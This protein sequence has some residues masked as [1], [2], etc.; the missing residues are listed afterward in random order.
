MNSQHQ[1]YQ[2]QHDGGTT[3]SAQQPGMTWNGSSW[4]PSATDVPP[5]PVKTYTRYYHEWTA[6]LQEQQ[7][8]HQDGSLVLAVREQAQQQAAWYKYHAD[9]SSRAAHH[10]H[11]NPA[12]STAPFDLPP[13][14]TA[15]ETATAGAPG[16]VLQQIH[17][18]RAAVAH[19]PKA[20]KSS[21]Q[22]SFQRYVDGCLEQCITPAEKAAVMKLVHQEMAKTM[23]EG[24]LHSTNWDQVPLVPVPGRVMP[25]TGGGGD[26]HYVPPAPDSLQRYVDGCLQQCS[27]P[28]EKTA[29]MKQVHQEMAKRMK[30]E[31]T[32]N[33]TNWDQVPLV[34]VPGRVMPATGGGGGDNHYVPPLATP[35]MATAATNSSDIGSGSTPSSDGDDNHYGP[36]SLTTAAPASPGC[37]A[38]QP[39]PPQSQKRAVTMATLDSELDDS[40]D[41]D[42]GD[43]YLDDSTDDDS[44]DDYLE[45]LFERTIDNRANYH[46]D[47]DED[48]YGDGGMADIV[49]RARMAGLAVPAYC[50]EYME[51]M[52]DD[53]MQ[54]RVTFIRP[55]GTHEVKSVGWCIDNGFDEVEDG[56]WSGP[57]YKGVR[58]EH[59]SRQSATKKPASQ[60]RGSVTS[61]DDGTFGRI[62]KHKAEANAAFSAKN[63]AAA[64]A[65]YDKALT[66]FPPYYQFMPAGQ[67]EEHV[68]ILSNKAECL[69]CLEQYLEAGMAASEALQINSKHVKSLFRRA[70]AS[71]LHALAT[72]DDYG[73][74]PFATAQVERDLQKI[75]DMRTSG[76]AGK[77]FAEAQALLDTMNARLLQ[78]LEGME[79]FIDPCDREEFERRRRG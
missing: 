77:G 66:L 43:D 47:S 78:D 56:I 55:E 7:A 46:D 68:N 50:Q 24:P 58:Q 16:F 39:P 53:R 57:W 2:Q 67:L 10:F 60:S 3:T 44:G 26:N 12:A 62:L 20:S 76:G 70:K 4:V 17:Q 19:S 18:P 30:E 37:V 25:A 72:P 36:P 51:E 75:I 34:P 41:D 73:I 71:Y 59:A 64:V 23:Q 5:N 48:F 14:P 27:T 45:D 22:D 13:A 9:Q 63:Y 6:K 65:R 11:Q 69:L 74:N 40:T 38:K 52:E 1:R 21:A 32:L 31:G 79:E 28:A 42:N 8:I 61:L 35:T 33:S 49:E 29:V 54:E 15:S